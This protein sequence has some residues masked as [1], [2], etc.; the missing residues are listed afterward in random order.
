MYLLL[1]VVWFYSRLTLVV[2]G[3]IFLYF[4]RLY[5]TSRSF[6]SV[7]GLFF[8]ILIL[9]IYRYFSWQTNLFTRVWSAENDIAAKVLSQQ[10]I[11]F[12]EF[13]FTP[14]SQQVHTTA[15]QQ[16]TDQQPS[17]RDA[18]INLL[19]ISLSDRSSTALSR[20][21]LFTTIQQLDPNYALI[22]TSKQ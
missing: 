14:T 12:Q 18:L 21:Q 17:H 11:L 2:A 16:L 7:T 4:L 9:T 10:S 22:D 19:L 8:C 3:D 5:F 6:L 20:Q 15:L 13:L 1:R